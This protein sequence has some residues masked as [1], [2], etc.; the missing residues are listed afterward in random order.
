M[1]TSGMADVARI[2]FSFLTFFVA[3]PSAVKVFNWLATLHQ[4][5]IRMTVPLLYTLGFIFLFAIGGFTG[6]IQGAL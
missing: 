4:G 5:S 3:V 2:V 6:L 1:F